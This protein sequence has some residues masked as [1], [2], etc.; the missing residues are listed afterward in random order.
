MADIY[1]NAIFTV[2]TVDQTLLWKMAPVEPFLSKRDRLAMDD[3]WANP[4]NVYRKLSDTGNFASWDEGDPKGR[5]WC[6]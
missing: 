2:T 5:A 6:F 1:I 4:T 3:G